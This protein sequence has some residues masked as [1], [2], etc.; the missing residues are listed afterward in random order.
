[1]SKGQQVYATGFENEVEI[2]CKLDLP[3]LPAT[4]QQPRPKLFTCRYTKTQ[5]K[6][7][8][9]GINGRILYYLFREGTL[10]IKEA[11]IFS[12]LSE[13]GFYVS[14]YIHGFQKTE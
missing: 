4:H 13:T 12:S 11:S 5:H 6:L 14:P 8:P 3:P 1:M 10:L 2:Y 7:T 9:V